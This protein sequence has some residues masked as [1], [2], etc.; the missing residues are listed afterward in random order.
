M[1]SVPWQ[2]APL[3]GTRGQLLFN[4]SSE[5]Q[6]AAVFWG[7]ASGVPILVDKMMAMMTP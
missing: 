1:Y 5:L 4:M 2:P 7:K 3:L 6:L